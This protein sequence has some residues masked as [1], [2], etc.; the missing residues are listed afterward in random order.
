[1]A[2]RGR[3]ER[4]WLLRGRLASP[5]EQEIV[6]DRTQLR[7]L[8]RELLNPWHPVGSS[9]SYFSAQLK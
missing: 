9:S 4:R 1:M 8:I 2:A 6:N 3:M 5:A 7:V